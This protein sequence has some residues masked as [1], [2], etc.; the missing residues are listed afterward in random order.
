MTNKQKQWCK[1]SRIYWRLCGSR[2]MIDKSV[3]TPEEVSNA[4]VVNS[5]ISFMIES[6][7]KHSRILGFKA[8]KRCL[9]CGKPISDTEQLCPICEKQGFYKPSSDTI[10]FK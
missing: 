10:R 7:Y 8:K 2:I 9:L 6:F 1:R 5:M 3:M 4:E